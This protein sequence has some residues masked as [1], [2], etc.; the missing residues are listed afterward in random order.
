MT[1][2]AHVR[3]VAAGLLLVGTLAACGGGHKASVN[4]AAQGTSSTVPIV[5]TATPTTTATT[6]VTVQKNPDAAQLVAVLQHAGLP[7]T[8]VIV[9]TAAT[10]P[11][12]L[13]GRPT[14]YTSKVSWTDTR[15]PADTTGQAAIVDGGSIEVYPTGAGA[16]GRAAYIFTSETAAPIIGT[17]YDYL[18]GAAIVRV[19]G[20]LTPDQA[21][22]F[23]KAVGGK[24]YTGT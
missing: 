9:Y 5:T 22:A 24:L 4:P 18:T 7:I 6:A 20:K 11:N 21:A 19:S 13:L 2:M 14:G 10:D 3:H 17:E 8:G 12:S 16:K 1:V 23:G 15:V